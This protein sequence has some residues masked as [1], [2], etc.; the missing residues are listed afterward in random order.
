MRSVKGFVVVPDADPRW[1][2][3]ASIQYLP[4]AD[5]GSTP[6]NQRVI[7]DSRDGD[8]WCTRG[9]EDWEPGSL[10]GRKFV[11]RRELLQRLHGHE[12]QVV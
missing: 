6:G 12:R 9:R 1:S 11:G 8:L 4:I 7:H 2:T 3:L 10:Q 5:Q